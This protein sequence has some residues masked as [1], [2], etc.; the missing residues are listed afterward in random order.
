MNE[1]TDKHYVL[2]LS[3]VSTADLVRELCS[4]EGVAVETVSGWVDIEPPNKYIIEIDN[5]HGFIRSTGKVDGP[6]RIIVIRGDE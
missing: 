1:T 3:G 4:R 2:D 5:G 6:A